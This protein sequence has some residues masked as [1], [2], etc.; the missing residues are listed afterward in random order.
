MITLTYISTATR[1]L[2]R[3]EI[4]ALLST[5]RRNNA[6]DG[7]TGMLLYADTHWIQTLEGDEVRLDATMEKIR[8][9]PRHREVTVALREEIDQRSFSEWSLGCRVLTREQVAAIPGFN[10]YLDPD[11][12]FYRRS[13]LGR[14]G[15]FHRI[16]RETSL[17]MPSRAP[18]RGSDQ[19]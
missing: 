2:D 4:E 10:D 17:L 1:V 14:A 5:S 6:R 9:D 15:T 13:N 11:S 7:L 16:F 12:E 8:A 3:P 19:G 18:K